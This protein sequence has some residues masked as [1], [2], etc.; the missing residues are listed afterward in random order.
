[1]SNTA[2]F[3]FATFYKKKSISQHEV[4]QQIQIFLEDV[5]KDASTSLLARLPRVRSILTH[6]NE[7]A[8]INTQ[9]YDEIFEQFDGKIEIHLHPCF[10]QNTRKGINTFLGDVLLQYWPELDGNL[11]SFS[12]CVP[13]LEGDMLGVNP[14]VQCKCS[15]KGISLAPKKDARGVGRVERNSDA[16]YIVV[17]TLS[18]V[19]VVIKQKYLEKHGF[20]YDGSWIGPDNKNILGALMEF[21][22]DQTTT[23]ENGAWTAKS[24]KILSHEPSQVVNTD[25]NSIK[26][27]STRKSRSRSPRRTG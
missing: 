17:L 27:T 3:R 2:A 10:L 7:A 20:T 9:L 18:L 19:N 13:T 11:I 6:L 23:D 26:V 12:S 8:P 15:F 14:Y 1:M 16:S 25:E 21:K 4:S 22:F 24:P 5:E